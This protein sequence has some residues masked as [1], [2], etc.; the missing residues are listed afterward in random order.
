M[1]TT[2]ASDPH[3]F[4]VRFDTARQRVLGLL[5]ELIPPCNP[6]ACTMPPRPPHP[7]PTFGDD[8]QL[9]LLGDWM[10]MVLQVICP[11]GKA[12]FCPSCRFVASRRVAPNNSLMVRSAPAAPARVSNHRAHSLAAILRDARLRYA[13]PGS[14]G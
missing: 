10:T 12:K 7:I 1:P 14:S 6:I 3:V 13:A 5:T 11:S 8:G 9:P 2:E 4:A